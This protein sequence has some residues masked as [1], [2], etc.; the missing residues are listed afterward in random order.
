MSD[1]YNDWQENAASVPPLVAAIMATFPKT[2]AGNSI[3][4][5]ASDAS[6]RA[7]LNALR[8]LEDRVTALE[9]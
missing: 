4:P 9:G 7:T 6:L 2:Q 1:A 5:V 8:D 3:G